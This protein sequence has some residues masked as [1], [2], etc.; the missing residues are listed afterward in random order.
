MPLP[1]ITLPAD[2][3]SA[4]AGSYVSAEL[5]EQLRETLAKLTWH[6]LYGKSYDAS[7]L[8]VSAEQM[9]NT[10]PKAA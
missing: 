8:A 7:G 9:L 5:A 2:T 4:P 1:S 3:T 10:L 6:V